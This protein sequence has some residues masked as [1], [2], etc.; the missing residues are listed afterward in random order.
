MICFLAI[1]LFSSLVKNATYH[2]RSLITSCKSAK[3][4]YF[5]FLF[6]T[7]SRRRVSFIFMTSLN[8]AYEHR[9]VSLYYDY[10]PT[11]T[12]VWAGDNRVNFN[13]YRAPNPHMG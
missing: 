12:K 11:L 9:L 7:E 6:Y 1:K 13:Y 5:N 2:F 10:Y 4:L 8:R 3:E